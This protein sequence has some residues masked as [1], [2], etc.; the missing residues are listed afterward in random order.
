MTEVFVGHQIS[1][2]AMTSSVTRE[3]GIQNHSVTQVGR[4]VRRSLVQ[5]KASSELRSGGTGIYAAVP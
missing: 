2:A 1:R 5:S 4:S 3:A